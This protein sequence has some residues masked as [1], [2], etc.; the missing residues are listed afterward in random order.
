MQVT[1]ELPHEVV[2]CLVVE[3]Y[4]FHCFLMFWTAVVDAELVQIQTAKSPT[5]QFSSGES[6]DLT[7]DGWSLVWNDLIVIPSEGELVRGT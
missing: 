7:I 3:W 4:V 2:Q 6:V 5:S 1:T